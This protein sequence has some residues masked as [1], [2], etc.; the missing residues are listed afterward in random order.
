M[1]KEDG[2]RHQTD[3]QRRLAGLLR[4]KDSQPALGGITQQGQHGRPFVA[5]S[6]HIGRAGIFRAVTA[7]IGQ[8][9][10]FRHDH[11]EGDG[12]HQIGRQNGQNNHGT[13]R[14]S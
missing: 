14:Q 9:K 8:P 2:Q 6:E 11:G 3:D 5:A 12:T 10:R 7:R 13:R 4:H 1:A